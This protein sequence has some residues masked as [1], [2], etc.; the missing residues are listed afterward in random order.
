MLYESIKEKIAVLR[1][2]DFSQQDEKDKLNNKK[3]TKA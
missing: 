2:V 3:H 1:I